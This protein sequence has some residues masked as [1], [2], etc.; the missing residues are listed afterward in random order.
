MAS[1]KNRGAYQVHRCGYKPLIR[2]VAR[3]EDKL[4]RLVF[5]WWGS[6]SGEL[7]RSV[8]SADDLWFARTVARV[9]DRGVHQVHGKYNVRE[10]PNLAR[11]NWA[12][13]RLI[14]FMARIWYQGALT[15]PIA[16]NENQGVIKARGEAWS[17][18]SRHNIDYYQI[19]FFKSSPFIHLFF[20]SKVQTG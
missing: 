17:T 14:R 7:S 3:V 9:M 8:T 6:C 12:T 11:G 16:I 18:F 5:L 19:G 15:K 20:R 13:A 2:S 4:T 10:E 1:V